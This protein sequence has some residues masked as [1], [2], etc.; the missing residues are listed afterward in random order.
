MTRLRI[1][2]SGVRVPGG[3]RDSDRLW[4][5]PSLLFNGLR[6]G[7]GV[8]WPGREVEVKNERGY[9]PIQLYDFMTCTGTLP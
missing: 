9:A 4:G 7:P 6:G 2:R 3:A 8:K 1:G 5:S